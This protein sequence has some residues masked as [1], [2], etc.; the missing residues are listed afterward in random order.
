M[1]QLRQIEKTFFSKNQTLAALTD[2]SLDIKTGEAFGVIGESGAGKSTL[3]RMINALE[4]PDAGSVTVDGVDL[5]HLSKKDLRMEQKQIGM[6][7]QQFN[8]LNNKTVAENI[9]LPLT[10]HNYDQTLTVDEVLDFVGLS[11]K[12]HSYPQQLSGGQ[13]QRVGIAR[14][15]ITRPKLLLC[16]E[17]TS[18]LDQNTTEDIVAVL[19]KAHREFKMTIV[20]VTHE[21]PVIKAL[22]TRAALMEYGKVRQIVD[23]T[24]S[25]D[26]LTDRPY[27]ERAIEV[28]TSD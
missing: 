16:D 13:K 11:D 24:R 17:P 18:A 2:I 4:T 23:I 7:F 9:R 28:L 21:L 25:E 14:A 20:V 10:L 12:K 27:L 19:K 3:L 15:L 26:K 5:T 6:I 22:C 8:L 1:I